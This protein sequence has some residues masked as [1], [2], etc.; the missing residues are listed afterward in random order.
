M[1]EFVIEWVVH[2]HLWEFH[3]V[4]PQRDTKTRQI[5]ASDIVHLPPGPA[6]I[7]I[8]YWKPFSDSRLSESHGRAGLATQAS[9][10]GRLD[11]PSPFTYFVSQEIVNLTGRLD[12]P[13][14]MRCICICHSW[15]AKEFHLLQPESH[16]KSSFYFSEM[17]TCHAAVLCWSWSCW[18]IFPIL[19]SLMDQYCTRTKYVLHKLLEHLFTS[20]WKL[21]PSIIHRLYHA[22]F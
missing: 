13:Y 9:K 10:L 6:E 21:F 16:W 22:A 18:Q 12:W 14:Q 2:L 15:D 7:F 11:R 8:W 5:S 19:Q 3:L 20:R 17:K 1:T 4:G